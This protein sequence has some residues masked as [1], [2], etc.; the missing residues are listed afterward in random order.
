M[1]GQISYFEQYTLLINEDDV[2][3]QVLLL[4]QNVFLVHRFNPFDPEMD[5]VRDICQYSLV[6]AY[7]YKPHFERFGKFFG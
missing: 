4:L 6:S 3:S 5:T 7:I 2:V 1:F